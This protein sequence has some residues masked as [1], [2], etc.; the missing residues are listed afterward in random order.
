MATV[1]GGKYVGELGNSSTSSVTLR[2]FV[3]TP[4][5]YKMDIHSIVSGTRQ[6]AISVNGRSGQQLSVTGTS[7]TQTAPPVSLTIFLDAGLNT[8][9]FYNNTAYAPSLDRII[10]TPTSSNATSIEAENGTLNGTSVIMNIA[11]ASGGKVVGNVG[12]GA[13][14]YVTMNVDAP[15]AGKYCL[16]IYSVVSGTRPIFVS[17]NA[18]TGKSINASGNSWTEDAPVVSMDVDLNAGVNTVKIY[19][20]TT[21]T[22]GIDKIELAP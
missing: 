9:K 17:V 20:D 7:W 5:F 18:G 8:I 1:S 2:A 6:Y 4:G 15:T 21:Y 13:A 10:L 22:P 11:G 12:N 3:E 16:L 14:N 19:N